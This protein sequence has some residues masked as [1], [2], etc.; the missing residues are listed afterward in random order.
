MALRLFVADDHPAIVD[1]VSRFLDSEDD[2]S[3]VGSAGDGADAL[4]RIQEIVPDVAIL[5]VRMP[6]MDGVEVARRLT[7]AG[8]KTATILYTAHSERA[9]VIEAIDAGAHGFVLKESP[10]SDLVRAVR[11]VG[12]GRTYVDPVLAGILV[13]P[14]AT[15]RNPR[16]HE[17]RARGPA[18]ARRR[19]AQRAGGARALDLPAHR[20]DPH[21]EGDGEAR[22][23]HADTGGRERAP[24][25]PHRVAILEKEDLER[26]QDPVA[27]VRPIR[28]AL[29]MDI[30]HERTLEA[31]AR[32]AGGIAH[33][34]NNA[35]LPLRAYGEIALK[36]IARGED[37]RE[38]VAEMLAASSRASALT[39][40]LLAFSGR[41][42][43]RPEIVD[44]NELVAG[45]EPEIA[46]VVG[47][48]IALVQK[49][50]AGARLRPRRPQPPRPR[51]PRI[52]PRT[53][54]RR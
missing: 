51:A 43:V 40:Q 48:G 1:S 30:G 41:Q 18:A 53:R 3:V 24:H 11:L 12:E 19:D 46:K 28:D 13:G 52:S 5:D 23:G 8:S 14:D 50:H 34:L 4:D 39:R 45:L 38:E 26:R 9:L 29:P 49:L 35:L 32:L 2:L 36:K 7:A 54:A 21:R 22:G 47:P 33:D 6:E 27:R 15:A 10:L 16:H 31:V 20:A 42:V 37:A 17:A 44:L 25:V